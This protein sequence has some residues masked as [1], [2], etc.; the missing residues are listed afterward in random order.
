MVQAVSSTQIRRFCHKPLIRIFVIH[1][2]APFLW[3]LSLA[4]AQDLL[5]GHLEIFAIDDVVQLDSNIREEHFKGLLIPLF[6][7]DSGLVGL[8]AGFVSKLG[9]LAIHNLLNFSATLAIFITSKPPLLLRCQYQD[10][11]S[12]VHRSLQLPLPLLDRIGKIRES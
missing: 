9:P 2:Y 11:V 10:L 5:F 8:D 4:V 6:F 3:F 12:L 1:V 7:G